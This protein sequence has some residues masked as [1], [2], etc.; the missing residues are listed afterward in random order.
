MAGDKSTEISFE[1][2]AEEAAVIDGYCNARGIKRTVV[3]RQLLKEWSD[4]KLHESILICRVAGVN[5]MQSGSI[6]DVNHGDIAN[7]QNK[8][9]SGA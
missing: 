7:S 9:G 6:R 2:S 4:Q 5:P 8:T 3:M 1:A